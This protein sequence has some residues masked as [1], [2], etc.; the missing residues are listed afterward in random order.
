MYFKTYKQKK[1]PKN[2]LPIL[3]ISKNSGNI[4]S[5]RNTFSFISFQYSISVRA[6]GIICHYALH[7]LGYCNELDFKRPIRDTSSMERSPRSALCLCL[8]RPERECNGYTSI[9]AIAQNCGN[10][11]TKPGFFH[12]IGSSIDHVQIACQ[13]CSD[14]QESC[15]HEI[16]CISGKAW[17]FCVIHRHSCLLKRLPHECWML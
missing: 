3:L 12:S 16:F 6:D 1:S 9:L 4:Y 11:C 2:K 15:L 8:Q 13:N 17:I 10:T 7:Q 14:G 5:T